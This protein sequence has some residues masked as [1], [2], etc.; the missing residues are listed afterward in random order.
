MTSGFGIGHLAQ[1]TP[2]PLKSE[3]SLAPFLIAARHILPCTQLWGLPGSWRGGASQYRLLPQLPAGREPKLWRSM[4][5]QIRILGFLLGQGLMLS[6]YQNQK[7]F[8][9][10]PKTMCP[11]L[12]TPPG[13]LSCYWPCRNWCPRPSSCPCSIYEALCGSHRDNFLQDL[14]FP[15]QGAVQRAGQ[16]PCKQ[17][18]CS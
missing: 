2:D 11:E 13:A 3:A 1:V 12:H 9:L 6:E 15:G 18:V 16:E 17:V 4:D 7:S 8:P 14:R 5:S 10:S